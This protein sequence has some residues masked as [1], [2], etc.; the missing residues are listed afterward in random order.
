[1]HAQYNKRIGPRREGRKHT[2][3]VTERITVRT[4]RWN[5]DGITDTVT[6]RWSLLMRPDTVV[7]C[8]PTGTATWQ[9]SSKHNVVLDS[10]WYENMSSRKTE[11][12]Q[13]C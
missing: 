6:S 3:A 9:I 13:R 4:K 10:T 8:R 12:K 11:V 1:V 5:V 2:L 7:V